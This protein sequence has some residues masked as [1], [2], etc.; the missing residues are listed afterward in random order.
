MNNVEEQF[1]SDIRA[2]IKK[3]EVNVPF[4]NRGFAVPDSIPDN[5]LLFIGIN[6]SFSDGHEPDAPQDQ[7]YQHSQAAGHKYFRKFEE[8]GKQLN[9]LW[10][11]M[12]LLLIRETKQTKVGDLTSN[13][14]G[15]QFI[16]ENLALSRRILEATK[17]LALVVNNTLARTYLGKDKFKIKDTEHNIWMGYEF[18][19][20]DEIGTYKITSQESNLLGKHVFFTSMLTGQRALDKGSLER[21]TWQLK[22]LGERE[23]WEKR[24]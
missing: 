24:F 22:K 18:E 6:P 17:P 11:H 7:F 15:L 20:D 5:S 10:S 21:L 2:L 12:D 19:W 23:N 3:Y 1:G 8:L 16:I 4:L 9:C 13:P 14:E